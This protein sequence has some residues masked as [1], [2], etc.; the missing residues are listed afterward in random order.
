[1]LQRK[2]SGPDHGQQTGVRITM[3]SQQIIDYCLT[4]PGAFVDFPFGPQAVILKVKSTN[5]AARIFAQLFIL[6]GEPC[7]TFSCDRA[8]GEVYRNVYPGAVT[9]GYHCPPVQQPYFNTVRLTGEVPDDEIKR[10]IDH[11]YAA[12][13]A[14]LPKYARKELLDHA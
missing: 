14:K 7:A 6:K 12:V 3:T 2:R 4:K 8:T 13:T 9:R 10:M 5:S 1:M 11:A